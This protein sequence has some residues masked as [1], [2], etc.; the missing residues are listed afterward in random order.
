MIYWRTSGEFLIHVF[1]LSDSGQAIPIACG[2]PQPKFAASGRAFASE[3]TLRLC[4]PAS[5]GGNW[6]L[7]VESDI[8]ECL[9]VPLDGGNSE[10]GSPD[11]SVHDEILERV[12][13]IQGQE[14][15]VC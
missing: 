12:E 14:E 9:N 1:V 15:F 4:G 2:F 6:C 5:V 10:I 8:E 7:L 13:L 11:T 3:N